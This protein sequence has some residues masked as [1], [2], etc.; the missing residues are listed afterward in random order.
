M[1]DIFTEENPIDYRS[2][3]DRVKDW[4]SK[5]KSEIPRIYSIIKAIGT[6]KDTDAIKIPDTDGMFKLATV[7]TTASDGTTSNVRH[8]FIYDGDSSK[9]VDIGSLTKYFGAV[10]GTN[11]LTK[12]DVAANVG[13]AYKL[14]KTDANGILPTSITGSAGKISDT[15][16]AVTHLKDGQSLV[17]R[18]AT[19]TWVN[20]DKGTVG[21]GKSLALKRGETIIANYSGDAEAEADISKWNDVTLDKTINNDATATYIPKVDGT[22]SENAYLQKATPESEAKTIPIRDADG[23][24]LSETPDLADESKKTATTS[25]VKNN[26][27]SDSGL[28]RKMF[29]ILIKES[30]YDNA[31]THNALFRGRDITDYWTSGGMYAAIAAG[32]VTGIYPGD[33]I[34]VPITVNG[35]TT[36]YD[37]VI[38]DCDYHLHRGDAETTAHH[39]LAFTR[40]HIG[41]EHMNA[42]NTT[43][44]GYI[45]SDMWKTI[46]PKYT[47]AIKN[48][49]GSSHI[50]TH[51]ELL[52]NAESDTIASAAGAGWSGG[53]TGWGWY[54][55]DVN[56]FNEPMVYGCRPFSSSA[57]DVGDCNTQV[58]AMIHDK[59]LSFTRSCWYWLRAVV[60]FSYFAIAHSDGFADYASASAGI[61]GVRVYFLLK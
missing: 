21:S 3:G 18:S 17:Y 56:L 13:E 47:T 22:A 48:A 55:V 27:T 54:D 28:F 11:L 9:W 2:G 37:I 31:G 58:A 20:E 5:Y 30:L 6:H 4:G 52:S 42:T 8:L 29:N 51:R 59:S 43:A 32:T 49:F 10:D 44:G 50:L 26:F 25:F 33:Y 1:T 12:D 36:T 45:G 41:K 16:I 39:V 60:S 35:A 19:N 38:G 46:L 23:F 40:I 14:I 15:N 61:G 24:L 7:T 57:F 53:S 34:R